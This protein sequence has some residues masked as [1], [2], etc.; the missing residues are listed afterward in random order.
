MFVVLN[1]SVTNDGITINYRDSGFA[2]TIAFKGQFGYMQP[3]YVITNNIYSPDN[4]RRKVR[5]LPVRTY[6]LRTDYLLSCVTQKI[7]EKYLLAANQ[8]YITDWNASNHIQNEY[9]NFP[10]ILS[11]DE[12]PNFE[13]DIS[14]YAKVTAVFKNRQQKDESKYS[15]DIKGSDNIILDLPTLVGSTT[16]EITSSTAKLLKT[17]ITVSQRTGDDGGTQRGRNIDRFTQEDNNPFGN[18]RRLTG[19]TGG[20]HNGTGYV[21]VNQASTTRLLAFPNEVMLDWSTFHKDGTVLSFYYGDAEAGNS[22]SWNDSVDWGDS[23]VHNTYSDWHLMNADEAERINNKGTNQSL[24]YPPIMLNV[25]TG[26][27]TSSPSF[28]NPTTQAHI[29]NS[30]NQGISPIPIA[31]AF[32]CIAVREYTLTE[33]GL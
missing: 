25:S 11:K 4:D 17:N 5:I 21:D 6:E 10:V 16:P 18:N 12:S 33:L 30:V 3:N 14:V 31:N 19:T 2:T 27:W 8:I 26:Y 29:V 24:N 9:T 15:G 1:D 22:R 20:S 32:R 23:L 13:Y 7:D 28:N